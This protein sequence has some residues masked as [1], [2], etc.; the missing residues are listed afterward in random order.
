[1]THPDKLFGRLGNRLF[2]GAYL[3]AQMREGK[4]PDIYCQDYRYFEK[5]ADDLR[6][7]FGEDVGFIPLVGIHFRAGANPINPDEPRYDENPFYVNLSKTGYYEKAMA[8]FP[9]Q[10]FLVCSDDLPKAKEFFKNRQDVAFA[11]DSDELDD[12]NL[13]TSCKGLICANSSYSVMAALVNPNHP[14]VVAPSAKNW[15][16]DSNELRTILPPTWIRM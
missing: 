4:I 3:Y 13:L 2:Q 8:E 16:S 12:F 14:K 10:K 9:A 15:Y 6:Q 7:W 5:Y 1:M 11:E